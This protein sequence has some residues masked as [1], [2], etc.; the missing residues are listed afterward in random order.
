MVNSQGNVVGFIQQSGG[1]LPSDCKI[2]DI[3]LILKKPPRSDINNY[4]PISLISCVSKLL[5]W[6]L[7]AALDKEDVVGQEQNGFRSNRSCGDNIFILN[8][9]LEFNKSKKLLSHLLFV[10]L[11]EAYDRVERSILLTKLRQLNV[12]DLFISFLRNYYFQ[13]LVSTASGGE[14]TRS[15]F[16]K[17]GSGK[18]VTSVRSYSSSICR[19]LAGA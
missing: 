8:T 6:Q 16:Q 13:D 1:S 9:V 7:S 15:Q 19:N 18:A 10:V 17:G 11:K 12:P 5:V 14:R 2:G 3:V 4:R